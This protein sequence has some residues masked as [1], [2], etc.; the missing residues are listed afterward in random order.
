[1]AAFLTISGTLFPYI[2]SPPAKYA[3]AILSGCAVSFVMAVLMGVWFF[4]LCSRLEA[5]ILM[6]GYSDPN[7]AIPCGLWIRNEGK[8]TAF[9]V[10]VSDEQKGK[11]DL[12]LY[13]GQKSTISPTD[14]PVSVEVWPRKFHENKG[15]DN[16][17]R[18]LIEGGS[19]SGRVERFFVL[20]GMNGEDEETKITI[21]CWDRNDKR[22]KFVY[23]LWRAEGRA[24]DHPILCAPYHPP[25]PIK[26]LISYV[27]RPFS[28]TSQT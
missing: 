27:F 19:S 18:W 24:F 1:M 10:Y 9:K 5:P 4:I 26:R 13:L 25:N 15:R 23:R 17:G 7:A 16:K 11:Y 12:E 3:H 14:G 20:K 28:S 21:E 6:L 22:S 8:A 2:L